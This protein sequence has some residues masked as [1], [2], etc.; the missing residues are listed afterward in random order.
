MAGHTFTFQA[1]HIVWSTS[2]R[3]PLIEPGWAGRLYKYMG[4]ICRSMDCSMLAAGG[5]AD[6]VH[7]LVRLHPS[8]STADLMRVVKSKASG[9]LKDEVGASRSFAWQRGYG[10]FS[11]SEDRVERVAAYIENQETHHRRMTFQ[12][13]FIEFLERH[14][15][16]Y[17]P[18]YV[19]D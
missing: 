16:K 9:W 18:R 19:W 17:E 10:A 14:K 2:R 13:E 6:H 12:E 8:V 11:V 7:L 15:I 3:E 4:G 1:A 5:V